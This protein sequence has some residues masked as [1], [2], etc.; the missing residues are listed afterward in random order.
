[1]NARILMVE[2]DPALTVLLRDNLEYEGYVVET[3]TDAQEAIAKAR[4]NP[5]G[6]TQ[7]PPG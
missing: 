7:P 1:M 5:P 4:A 6:C 2:D 3:A